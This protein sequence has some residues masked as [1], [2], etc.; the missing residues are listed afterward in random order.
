MEDALNRLFEKWA[1][2]RQTQ[3]VPLPRSGSDRQYFRMFAG[4]RSAIGAINPNRRE[5]EAF[6]GFT[7][8]FRSKGLPVPE[9]YGA[10]PDHHVYLLEDLG[11]TTVFSLIR[12]AAGAPA[13]G[14][15]LTGIY[16]RIIE[17][18]PEFQVMGGRDLDY[19]L[20]YPRNKFDRQS[21]L[22][23]LN[24]FKYYFLRLAAVPFDEQA[25]E[26]DFQTFTGY[27][28]QAPDR[29]FLYRDFQSRN[30][31]VRDGELYFIDYQGGRQG[32]LQ[33]DLASLLYDAKANLPQ[34]F[35]EELLDHYLEVI[36]G[37]EKTDK[38]SFRDH[39]TGFVLIRIM[40]ALG[41]YGYRGFY[42]RKKHFLSSIPFALDN[43]RYLL[44][45][46]NVPVRLPELLPLLEKL[47]ASEKLRE[48]GST[49]L[50]VEI[51]SFSYKRG[52]PVDTSGHG[53]GHVFDCRPLPNPGRLEQY[54]TLTGKD[55]EVID[56]LE[57]QP[58]V[59]QYYTHCREIVELSVKNYL[60]RDFDHL[61]IGFGCTGGQHRSVYMAERMAK[62]LREQFEFQVEVVLRHREQGE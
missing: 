34:P 29:Y 14:T 35:R 8:H 7:R 3:I 5:N 2:T 9:I 32:A 44:I 26:D 50:K 54:R 58:E 21:M 12:E 19:G 55:R 33:Y 51:N 40:Q 23:D 15:R 27:L 25:L 41:A 30:I 57:G 47:A 52:I 39:F 37:Y 22:W 24:Y 60:N 16:K 31:M 28:L 42:E 53:G 45:Q 20:C 4:E 13:W 11:D 38:Q 61:S 17:K 18:L 10:D 62:Y 56:Y 48:M 49:L 1:G 36:N 46:G 6:I 59:G 43:L